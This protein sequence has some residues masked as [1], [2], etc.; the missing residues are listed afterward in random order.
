MRRAMRLVVAAMCLFPLVSWGQSAANVEKVDG[1]YVWDAVKAVLAERHLGIDVFNES[2]NKMIT[3]YE[4]YPAHFMRYRTKYS[5]E[6]NG[7]TLVVSLDQKQQQLTSGWGNP[8]VPSKGADDKLVQQMAQAVTQAYARVVASAPA[9]APAQAPAA[10]AAPQQTSDRVVRD[11]IAYQLGRCVREETR[12]DCRLTATNVTDSDLKLTYSYYGTWS[13]AIDESGAKIPVKYE[14]VGNSDSNGNNGG[15]LLMPGVTVKM[16]LIFQNVSA[17]VTRFARLQLTGG[18]HLP[19][20]GTYADVVAA[21]FANVPFQNAD[22]GAPEGTVLRGGIQIHLNGCA[23]KDD[24]VVCK[25]KMSNPGSTDLWLQLDGNWVYVMDED[26]NQFKVSDFTTPSNIGPQGGFQ[27]GAV[28]PVTATFR[29]LSSTVTTLT[30]VELGGLD[31]DRFT[32]RFA[33]VP[34]TA[35]GAGGSKA[36][37]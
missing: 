22:E 17:G 6:L 24:A 8:Q 2:T 5:F 29:G 26:G 15:T 11:G 31:G 25:W 13:F 3:V 9:P 35:A 10:D 33:N 21:Q 30:R 16:R 20:R 7:G 28:L 34:I 36:T 12:V 1:N 4:E 14:T 27:P 37:K 18:T 23:R 19:A 32:A